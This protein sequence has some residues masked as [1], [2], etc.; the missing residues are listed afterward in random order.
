ML[1]LPPNVVV[2]PFVSMGH[3]GLGNRG[4]GRLMPA[5]GVHQAHTR[6]APWLHGRAAMGAYETARPSQG[7]QAGQ[8]CPCPQIHLDIRSI[9][10]SGSAWSIPGIVLG[11]QGRGLG[12]LGRSGPAPVPAPRSARA[13]DRRWLAYPEGVRH[14]VWRWLIAT[15]SSVGSSRLDLLIHEPFAKAPI[16]LEPV[17]GEAQH[18]EIPLLARATETPGLDVVNRQ[19]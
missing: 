8:A 5:V 10:G 6:L 19:A 2:L 9:G 17:V 11:S 13:I 7:V 4:S 15:W 12:L 1:L 18:P 3:V 16:G 14:L